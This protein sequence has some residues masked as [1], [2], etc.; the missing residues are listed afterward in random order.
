[1]SWNDDGSAA[2]RRDIPAAWRQ[3]EQGKERGVAWL[4]I[5]GLSVQRG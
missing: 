1:M 2:L 3:V 5:A 4:L